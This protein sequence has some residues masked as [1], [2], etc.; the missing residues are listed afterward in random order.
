MTERKENPVKKMAIL[1]A[2]QMDDEKRIR[3][4]YLNAREVE[5]VKA[6]GNQIRNEI[7]KKGFN[8]PSILK[9]VEEYKNLTF[10]E[11]KDWIY[12]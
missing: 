11:Y 10:D 3:E 7:V 9:Y 12:K 1:L 8:V 4:G 2:F 5:E 6:T